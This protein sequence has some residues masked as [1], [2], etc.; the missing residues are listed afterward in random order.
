VCCRAPV[1]AEPPA[2]QQKA[3]L[4]GGL[5]VL[6]LSIVLAVFGGVLFLSTAVLMLIAVRVGARAARRQTT[7]S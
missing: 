4:I 6:V 3:A 2:A 5:W 7:A 1:G